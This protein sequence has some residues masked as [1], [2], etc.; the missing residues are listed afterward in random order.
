MNTEERKLLTVKLFSLLV[1]NPGKNKYG[2]LGLLQNDGI[3]NYSISDI[4]SVLYGNQHLFLKGDQTLPTWNINMALS[5]IDERQ[6]NAI[7]EN[8]DL[9]WYKGKPPRNWQS[10]A[11][12]LWKKN[13]RIGVIEAV[14][15]SGKTTVGIIAAADAIA[16]GFSVVVLVPGIELL[17]QWHKVLVR[18]LPGLDIGKRCTGEHDTIHSHHIFVVTVQT[19]MRHYILPDGRRGLLIADEVHRYGSGEFSKALEDAFEERLGLTATYDRRDNGID[20]ILTPYFSK[21]GPNTIENSVIQGCGYARGLNDGI[22]AP[23]RVG[24]L[25]L[26]LNPADQEKYVSLDYSLRKKR[27]RLIEDYGCPA[28][29]F[30]EFI[31]EVKKLSEGGNEDHNSS[32]IARQ[33]LIQFRER[34]ILLSDSPE[35]IQTLDK[36]IPLFFMA[37]KSLIFTETIEAA[38]QSAELLSQN[39]IKA[40]SYG[41][42]LKNPERTER[43]AEFATGNIKVL[44]APRALDEGVDVP[45]A[46]FGV[47][48]SASQTKRQMIQRMGRIIRPK[49]DS[50]PATFIIVYFKNTSE[51]PD[52]GAHEAF[53]NEMIDHA[54]EVITFESNV[55]NLDILQ[56]YLKGI[57]NQNE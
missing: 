20:E 56:W 45:E 17:E 50:R 49:K 52:F 11:L 4:N 30:G 43:M 55:S 54:N 57:K 39:N 15:G 41:S 3:F 16:R 23:F 12:M 40:L 13:G 27:K 8:A 9:R 46:D 24:L 6:E 26:E 34:R 18:D 47:I 28:E 38:I 1:V 37:E 21:L 48:L 44:S 10:E 5:D 36:L 2:L 19:A 35:K 51:D 22:L 7:I 29:P 42:H 53:L 31:I 25:G 14:T 32:K 33:Y